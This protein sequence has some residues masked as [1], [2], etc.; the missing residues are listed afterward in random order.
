[1]DVRWWAPEQVRDHR[2]EILTGS[3]SGVYDPR[4]AGKILFVMSS[5]MAEGE[6]EFIQERTPIGLDTAAANGKHGGRSPVLDDDQLAI[7]LCRGDAGE[8]I[9]AIAKLLGVG[10]STIY[11]TL[12]AHEENGNVAVQA[13][14]ESGCQ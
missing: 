4:G 14:A 1:M 13:K 8:L 10:R 3:L 5:A 2:L 7:V 6:R 11:R 9:T 12:A